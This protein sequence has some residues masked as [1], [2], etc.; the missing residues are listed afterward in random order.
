MKKT[1]CAVVVHISQFIVIVHRHASVVGDGADLDEVHLVKHL[2]KC[3]T[4]ILTSRGQGKI[5]IWN[6]GFYSTCH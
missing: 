6:Y 3:Q 2:R 1:S 4:A 5:E